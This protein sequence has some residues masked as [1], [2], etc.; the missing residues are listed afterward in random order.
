MTNRSLGMGGLIAVIVMSVAVFVAG[1]IWFVWWKKRKNAR[2]AAAEEGSVE[3]VAAG[4]HG[5]ESKAVVDTQQPPPYQKVDTSGQVPPAYCEFSLFH[6]ISPV[7]YDVYD[8]QKL[9]DVLECSGNYR[10]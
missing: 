3:P 10:T 9:T 5:E 1:V 7:V 8:T 2:R 4:A 6:V